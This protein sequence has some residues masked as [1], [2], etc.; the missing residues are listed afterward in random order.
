MLVVLGITSIDGVEAVVKVMKTF[1]KCQTLQ[2]R[3]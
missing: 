1:P 3:A 2:E